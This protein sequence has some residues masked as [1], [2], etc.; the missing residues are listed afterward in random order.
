MNLG[1]LNIMC[2]MWSNG[3]ACKH[4]RWHGSIGRKLS[5]TMWI[6][7]KN[8]GNDSNLP[9][10]KRW[11][12]SRN[13][14]IHMWGTSRSSVFCHH[15]VCSR[16]SDQFLILENT[17]V[18]RWWQLHLR[19][20]IVPMIMKYLRYI[21]VVKILK[22]WTGCSGIGGIVVPTSWQM[23]WVYGE[24]PLLNFAILP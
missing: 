14:H 12:P 24:Y 19:Q 1:I 15:L 7:Q 21:S 5:K 13:G 20:K 10:L 4:Q 23:R 18:Q 11:S 8:F 9:Q 22:E 17:W 3:R 2:V 16:W 6:Y